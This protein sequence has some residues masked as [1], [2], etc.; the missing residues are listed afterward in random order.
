VALVARRPIR[1]CRSPSIAVDYRGL[2]YQTGVS[3]SVFALEGRQELARGGRYSAGYPED[4]VSEPAT[5]F[6]LYM[7]AVLAASRAPPMRPRLYLP[8]APLARGRALAG[9]GLR[10]VRAVRRRRRLR[11]GGQAA[12][13]ALTPDRRRTP[14][15][16]EEAVSRCLEESLVF[17]GPRA[18]SNEHMVCAGSFNEGDMLKI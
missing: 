6:T 11:A 15:P 13:A 1:N 9:Q 7:D 18:D 16:S 2:E 4:G 5:G 14:C 3:F 12:R 8:P 10:R 17:A